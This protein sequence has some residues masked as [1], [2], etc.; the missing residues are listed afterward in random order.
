MA[1]KP[2]LQVIIA[3]FLFAASSRADVI[4]SL[5]LDFTDEA[6]VRSAVDL[7]GGSITG[8]VFDAGGWTTTTRDDIILLPLPEGLEAAEGTLTVAFMNPEVDMTTEYFEQWIVL[9]LDTTGYPFRSTPTG[10]AGL[11]SLYRGYNPDLPDRSYRIVAYMNLYDPGC[12]DWHNCTGETGTTPDWAVADG[13]VYEI[14][15]AWLGA[16]DRIGFVGRSTL[17][18]TIDISATSPD[19]VIAGDRFHLMVNACGGSRDNGCGAWGG[20]AA[21]KGGPIGVTYLSVVLELMGEAAEEALEPTADGVDVSEPVDA[22]WEPM[23]TVDAVT[24][25]EPAD[26]AD[27]GQAGEIPDA[28]TDPV[29]DA[30]EDPGSGMDGGCGCAVLK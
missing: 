28:A 7:Y 11:Q 13:T 23:E 18:R 20:P 29:Q 9:S 17:S 15:H 6:A 2:L 25:E 16:V 27:E 14:R 24:P 30:P 5:E 1:K 12:D 8:G 3:I 22:P 10:L 4:F 26:A 19:G 21:M